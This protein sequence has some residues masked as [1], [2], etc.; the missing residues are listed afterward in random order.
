MWVITLRLALVVVFAAPNA[1]A[2]RLNGPPVLMV[3][4]GNRVRVGVT[5]SVLLL[6]YG[7]PSQRLVGTVQ[8]ITP[9]TL[10]LQV[11][12]GTNPSAIPREL[13][14]GVELSLGPPSRRA[15]AREWG[16]AGGVYGGLLMMRPSARRSGFENAMIGT[17]VGSALGV[18][19]G[20]V[21]PRE[22]WRIA[23]LPE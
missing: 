14:R 21:H 8:S 9:D 22:P 19:F 16:I 5:D 11:I 2:Q 3:S 1:G 7:A 4:A 13:I 23:W 20:L 17:A 6:P 18:L 12:G 10:Y 15:T